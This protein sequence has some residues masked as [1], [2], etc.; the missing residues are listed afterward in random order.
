MEQLRKRGNQTKT[1]DEEYN[2]F[3]LDTHKNEI[4]GELKNVDYKDLEDVV[5]RM[6]L[7]YSEIKKILYLKH[8]ATSTIGYTLHVGID[9]ISDFKEFTS[10]R[11]ESKH[12]N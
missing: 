11:K 4:I 7:F 5:L 1:G 10:K 6:E 8:I 3:D 9:E 12:Y 2:L